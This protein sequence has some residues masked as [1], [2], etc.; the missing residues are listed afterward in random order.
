MDNKVRHY[1]DDKID[2]SYDA[3]RCI[4]VGKCVGGLPPVFDTARRPWI[5]PGGAPPDAIAAVI[6]KCPSGALHY[7]RRDGGTAEVPPGQ[8]T[9][10]PRPN[11]PL[12]LR[13]CLKLRSA[14]GEVTI[15]DTRLALCR[16]GQSHNKPFCDRS[17]ERIGFT[18]D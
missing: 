13:G 14:N 9:V 15:E 7:V 6:E 18:G 16:C 11:G 3:R 17:H 4:H 2:I 8:A 10:V 12:Y 5:L 1:D